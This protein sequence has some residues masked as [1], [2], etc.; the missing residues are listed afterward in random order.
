M[1]WRIWQNTISAVSGQQLLSGAFFIYFPVC[2]KLLPFPFFD[3]SKRGQRRK[4]KGQIED[5]CSSETS[6]WTD[7]EVMQRRWRVRGRPRSSGRPAGLDVV[8]WTVRGKVGVH[9]AES[10]G[11]Q[12]AGGGNQQGVEKSRARG[13]V[14]SG[15]RRWWP[16]AGGSDQETG[17]IFERLQK[18]NYSLLILRK[19]QTSK[20]KTKLNS[21]S[22][23]RFVRSRR[24]D[25]YLFTPHRLHGHVIS[26]P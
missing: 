21:N 4:K 1:I 18:A 6:T 23:K 12:S 25:V 11:Y 9:T 20:L 14:G 24:I 22:Q 19:A 2:T 17:R 8:T 5:S 3:R 13:P 15:T 26:L 10:R 7:Q 16:P